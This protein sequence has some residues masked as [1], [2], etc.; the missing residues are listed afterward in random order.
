MEKT[1][2]GPTS[3]HCTTLTIFL[4]LK[5][6]RD[7]ILIWGGVDRIQQISNGIQ[8]I[9]GFKKNPPALNSLPFR[10]IKYLPFIYSVLQTHRFIHFFTIPHSSLLMCFSLLRMYPNLIHFLVLNSIQIYHIHEA[11]LDPIP[12]KANALLALKSQSTLLLILYIIITTDYLV[13]CLH[14]IW[15][16]KL[17]S[18]I[19]L[20]ECLSKG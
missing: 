18:T 3:N 13:E 4:S 10:Y 14:N 20:H 12:I 1:G 8:G 9:K 2:E 17:P 5:S 11:F 7:E 15:I 19:A 16:P 6:W